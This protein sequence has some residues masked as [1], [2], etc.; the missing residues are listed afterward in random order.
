MAFDQELETI[1]LV[2]ER[3]QR[4][5]VK[6]AQRWATSLPADMRRQFD[7]EL[8]ADQ[9]GNVLELGRISPLWRAT[10]ASF[11][12]DRRRGHATLSL[13]AA[14]GSSRLVKNTRDGFDVDVL[15]AT[16][17]RTAVYPQEG[18]GS[19]RVPVASYVTDYANRKARTLGQLS[20]QQRASLERAVL[21][22]VEPMIR[23]LRS[24]VA[25]TGQRELSVTAETQLATVGV[26]AETRQL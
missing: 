2:V 9:A 10:K 8:Y 11:G 3:I 20:T 18:G 25:I 24:S 16:Q 5:A 13:A 1:R 17:G 15:R 23:A 7:R 21:R 26:R 19:V 4:E 6:A 12:L 14:I 22:S